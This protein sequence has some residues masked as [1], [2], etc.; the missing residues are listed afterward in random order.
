MVRKRL[1]GVS[2]ETSDTALQDASVRGPITEM[3][4]FKNTYQMT[5]LTSVSFQVWDGYETG[6]RQ[7]IAMNS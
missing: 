6:G 3:D 5:N 1:M 2:G 7:G 4:L